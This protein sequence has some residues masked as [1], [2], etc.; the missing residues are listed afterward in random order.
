MKIQKH[1]ERL[2]ILVL[3]KEEASRLVMH[4]VSHFSETPIPG[5]ASGAIFESPCQDNGE[6]FSLAVTIEEKK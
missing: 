1:D 4:L 5:N 2:K 6:Y 3:S